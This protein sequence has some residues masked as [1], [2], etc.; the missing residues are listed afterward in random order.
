MIGR[1]AVL[2]SRH[3]VRNVYAFELDPERVERLVERLLPAFRE[4][5]NEL[6]AFAALVEG[7]AEES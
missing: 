2:A 5:G 4:A 6:R 1:Y 3:V 7:M